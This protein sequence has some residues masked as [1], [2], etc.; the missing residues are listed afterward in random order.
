MLALRALARRHQ[1]LTVEIDEL[2]A[3]I[4]PLVTAI[5]STLIGLSGVGT[6]CSVD[7]VPDGSARGPWRCGAGQAGAMSTALWRSQ[8]RA[9]GAR[10]RTLWLR[11]VTR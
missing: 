5:N 10:P 9:A 11:H 4:G 2:D 7:A 8:L 3:L 1:Q 6:G